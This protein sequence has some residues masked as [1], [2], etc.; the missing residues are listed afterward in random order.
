MRR[1]KS[2]VALVLFTVMMMAISC[3]GGGNSSVNAAIS[4]M[5]K[6]IDRV[7]KNKTAMTEAD[8][9][10]LEAELK[11]PA[12]ILEAALENNSVGMMEKLKITAVSLRYMTVLSEA[13]LNT[14]N[15]SLSVIN[16]Q[17]QEQL[18]SDEMKEALKELEKGAKELEKLLK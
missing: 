9:K 5:E 14:V 13:A 3:G 6:A 18:N 10:A 7:E 2:I 12:A 15:D 4:Q 8:W 17:L 1:T 11:E 16:E